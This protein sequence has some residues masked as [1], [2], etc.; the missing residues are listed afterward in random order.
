MYQIKAA[1]EKWNIDNDNLN[2]NSP[3]AF[4]VNSFENDPFTCKDYGTG[5]DYLSL[6]YEFKVLK[7][8]EIFEDEELLCHFLSLTKK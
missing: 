2:P 6:S 5:E 4:T 7:G 1:E 3:M 8:Y